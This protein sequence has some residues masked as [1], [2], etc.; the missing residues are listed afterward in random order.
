MA[1]SMASALISRI[2]RGQALLQL[3]LCGCRPRAAVSGSHHR[4]QHRHHRRARSA[5][6]VAAS[7]SRHRFAAHPSAFRMRADLADGSQDVQPHFA[8]VIRDRTAQHCDRAAIFSA[9][10]ARVTLADFQAA[11]PSSPWPSSGTAR[12]TGIASPASPPPTRTAQ[13]SSRERRLRLASDSSAS[14]A[15]SPLASSDGAALRPVAGRTLFTGCTP[16]HGALCILREPQ[17]QPCADSDARQCGGRL[18]SANAERRSGSPVGSLEV[19]QEARRWH[20]CCGPGWPPAS[21]FKSAGPSSEFAWP[22]SPRSA[23]DEPATYPRR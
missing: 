17:P 21:L 3:C 2:V 10:A 9:R 11:R 22:G 4:H 7:A 18:A 14:T 20:L 1:S 8:V 16:G 15:G 13:L 19:A 12:A 5:L 6:A 23:T